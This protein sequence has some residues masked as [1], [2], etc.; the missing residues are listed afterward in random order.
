MKH[1][2]SIEPIINNL[3]APFWDAATRG[4]LLLPW[5]AAT[6]RF[7][8]P[9]ASVSPFSLDTPIAWRPAE[10]GGTLQAAVTYR[11]GYLK[12]LDPI[13]PYSVGIVE[14]DAGPRLQVHLRDSSLALP[15]RHGQRVQ[16]FFEG[17]LP[18]SRP[19]PMARAV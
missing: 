5:C 7:F 2:E 17:L 12:V 8:W 13:M 14:L 4:D 11:R 9:P 6:Q 1:I 18:D 10:T 16:I 15:A 19:V 3:N